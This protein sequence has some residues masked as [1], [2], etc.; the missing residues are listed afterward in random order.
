MKIKCSISIGQ[1]ASLKEDVSY[2]ESEK[3][4]KILQSDT[5]RFLKQ[6]FEQAKIKL[7]RRQEKCRVLTGLCENIGAPEKEFYDD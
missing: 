6:A 3:D 1:Y 7:E 4:K 5:R 2:L